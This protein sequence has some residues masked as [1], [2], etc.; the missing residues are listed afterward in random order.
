MLPSAHGTESLRAILSTLPKIIRAQRIYFTAFLW[1]ICCESVWELYLLLEMHFSIIVTAFEIK[2]LSHFQHHFCPLSGG[3]PVIDTYF[4][5][6]LFTNLWHENSRESCLEREEEVGSWK[7]G[8]ER[9]SAL[10]PL[11]SPSPCSDCTPVSCRVGWKWWCPAH[12]CSAL[13][14]MGVRFPVA[15][16]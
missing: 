15:D 9:W 1:R 14:R 13:C 8:Q 3:L 5:I 7:E 16:S 10:W 4:A 11:W 2:T 6:S 12:L